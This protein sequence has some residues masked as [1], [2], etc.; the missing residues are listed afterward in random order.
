[1][2]HQGPSIENTKKAF[3]MP[4]TTRSQTKSMSE[5]KKVIGNL[6]ESR[7]TKNSTLSWFVTSI[8]N[9]LSL[10]EKNSDTERKLLAKGSKK[11][12]KMICYAN[13]RIST[14]IMYVVEQ[15]YPIMR[16][17]SIKM[18]KFG[19]T[20]YD[21]IH[22]LYNQIRNWDK[23][24]N[25]ITQEEKLV[26]NTYINV[27]YDTEK[28]IVKFLPLDYPKK[29]LC[30]FV[31][32]T[33]M[34]TIEPHDEYDGITDIWRDETLDY[35]PDYEFEEE[36][37]DSDEEDD[38]NMYIDSESEESEES[39]E[40]IPPNNLHISGPME[41]MEERKDGNHTRFIYTG[42]VRGTCECVEKCVRGTCEC[43]E[44]CV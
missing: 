14:E 21:K 18:D 36:E 31:D 15:Y 16:V 44:K 13:I 17:M 37:Y 35:D 4:V 22:D 27:L 5:N 20:V 3:K 41:M 39:E 6:E 42:F 34:D 1:M 8:K 33:F 23:S 2:L 40:Y 38:L 24:Y 12:A 28:M 32:Y 43:V 7:V 9:S 10:M 26:F 25:P 29:R 30:K 19:K 11:L